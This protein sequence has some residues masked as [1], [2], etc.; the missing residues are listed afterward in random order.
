MIERQRYGGPI[1]VHCD[2][3]PDGIDTGTSDFAEAM[4]IIKDDGWRVRHMGAGQGWCHF[5]PTCSHDANG[6]AQ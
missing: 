4:T 3:C 6:G 2:L 5:C 1:S